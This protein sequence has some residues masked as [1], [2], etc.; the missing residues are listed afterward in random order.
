MSEDMSQWRAVLKGASARQRASFG[1]GR[2]VNM[3]VAEW[4]VFALSVLGSQYVGH[5]NEQADMSTLEQMW[6]REEQLR[7]EMAQLL[8]EMER[9][10]VVEEATL[11]TV[12]QQW[13]MWAIVGAFLV[14]CGLCWLARRRKTKS[15]RS[16]KELSSS[17]DEEGEED[18]KEKARSGARRAFRSSAK[19]TFG[20]MQELANLC[21]EL[22]GDLLCVSQALCRNI[23]MPQL[24]LATGTRSTY[25]G[26]SLQQ[27]GL[28]YR[29]HVFLDPPPGFS[30]LLDLDPT[31][32]RP[33]RQS[34]VRLEL[35]CVCSR[36]RLLGDVKCILHHLNDNVGKHQALRL[37]RTLCTEVYLDT[38]KVASWV[39]V[40]VKKAWV[41]LPMSHHCQLTVLPSS[42]SC[43]LELIS[44]SQRSIFIE[45]IIAM[46][47]AE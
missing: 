41:L 32:Q 28:F 20:P 42:H 8:D 4:I 27:D 37:L 5:V 17:S 2:S 15:A 11:S 44:A 6:Q 22:V 1:L 13:H 10:V 39:Q 30:F 47:Q 26:W 12:F 35:N 14:L 9:K 18:N 29:V 7:R 38:D 36:E 34:D 25:N 16:R 19:R 24:Q 45:M 23:V 31:G 33:A 3:A 46:Q 40:L 43:K 21:K